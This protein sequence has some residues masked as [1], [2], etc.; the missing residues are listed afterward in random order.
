VASEPKFNLDDGIH[1]NAQGVEEIVKRILP[2][3]EEFLRMVKH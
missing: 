1:P 2:K 3:V